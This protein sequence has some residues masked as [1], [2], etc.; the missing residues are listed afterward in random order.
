MTG[1]GGSPAETDLWKDAQTDKVKR[2]AKVRGA[3]IG[4]PGLVELMTA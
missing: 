2:S 1:G 3:V 4:L